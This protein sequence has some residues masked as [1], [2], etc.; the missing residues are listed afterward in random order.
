FFNHAFCIFRNDFG[1]HGTFYDGGDF[2]QPLVEIDPFFGN[3]RRV[4][5]HPV[6]DA[7]VVRFTDF[8]D[9]GRIDEK[10]HT[11]SLQNHP[12]ADYALPDE[13]NSRIFCLTV[14]LMASRDGPRYLRGSYNSG[15][16]AKIWRTT[17]VCWIWFS[18]LTLILAV[19]RE[20]AR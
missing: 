2:T 5:R 18:V 20:M 11:L 14:S 16:S 1:A 3:E 12:A 7:E 8:G 17:F 19:P 15:F 9:I 4:R 6:Q 10:L 13:P